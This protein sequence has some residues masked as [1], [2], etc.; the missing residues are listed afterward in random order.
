MLPSS[1]PKFS[2][3][4]AAMSNFNLDFS[5]G[6]KHK[7]LFY[8]M[9]IVLEFDFVMPAKQTSVGQVGTYYHRVF[10]LKTSN[11]FGLLLLLH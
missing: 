11:S 10:S 8:E 2:A 3:L 9:Q 1:F 4:Q 7:T 6:E 5:L